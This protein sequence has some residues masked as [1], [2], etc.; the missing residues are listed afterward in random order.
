MDLRQLECFLKVAEHLHFGRASEELYLGQPTV[1]E[2]VR[3]LER[4]IGGALF[5]RTT[6]RVTLTSL[7]ALFLEEA[8]PAYDAIVLAYEAGRAGA[9]QQALKLVV[10]STGD[11][12]QQ[13][14]DAVAA[15]HR[16]AP[17]VIVTLRTMSTPEQLRALRERRLNLAICW[18]P[19]V[20]SDPVERLP[21]GTARLAAVVPSS[22]PFTARSSVTVGDLATEPL[23]VWARAVN[24]RL[25]DELAAAMNEAGTPW[26][27]VGTAAGIHD[28]AAHVLSGFGIGLIIET[29]ASSR[30]MKGVAV[31]PID[32]ELPGLQ[33]EL[34]WR[35]NDS[36]PALRR[37]IERVLQVGGVR[38]LAATG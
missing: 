37:F 32:V 21:I 34:V 8:K 13:L 14:V 2:S 29:F 10:G 1:S 24:P 11:F 6:R 15:F 26:T 25:Y 22:H 30:A 7:G 28:V 36:H 38:P 12:G 9:R 19:D 33:R 31:V 3:R 20:D 23:I 5:D 17:D 27:Y 35:R 16:A 4:E 18:A